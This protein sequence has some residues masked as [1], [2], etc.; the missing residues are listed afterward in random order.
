MGSLILEVVSVVVLF[1]LVDDELF[2]VFDRDHFRHVGADRPDVHPRLDEAEEH[3]N[4]K[5]DER[6]RVAGRQNPVPLEREE[7]YRRDE[8]SPLQEREHRPP[9][10]EEHRVECGKEPKGREEGDPAGVFEAPPRRLQHLIHL[11]A[12]QYGLQQHQPEE[13][14]HERHQLG[15][16][17]HR[18]PRQVPQQDVGIVRLA[19]VVHEGHA[20]MSEGVVDLPLLRIAQRVVRRLHLLEAGAGFVLGDDLALVPHPPLPELVRVELEGPLPVGLLDVVGVGISG[21]VEE[22]VVVHLVVLRGV[23][24]VG[25]EERRERPREELQLVGLHGRLQRRYDGIAIAA[26][27][28]E[29]RTKTK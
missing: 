1:L 27:R 5:G 7:Q 11:R 12:Q 4:V 10:D 25:G 18:A 24:V 22:G 28:K 3:P 20:P 9:D 19:G 26:K 17:S 16:I 6:H 13:Y 21:D 29:G 15:P 14:H 23:G 8:R 2:Y